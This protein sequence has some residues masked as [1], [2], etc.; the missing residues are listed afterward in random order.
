M[1]F[2]T[3]PQRTRG[4]EGAL[5]MFVSNVTSLG[6]RKKEDGKRESREKAEGRKKEWNVGGNGQNE[7]QR[8][9]RT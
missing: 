3:R 8:D 2:G 7:K 4:G 5:M 9:G 1:W 6:W